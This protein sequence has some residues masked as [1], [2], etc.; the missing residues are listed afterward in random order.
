M[1]KD[2]E[3]QFRG[4]LGSLRCDGLSAGKRDE[5]LGRI[6]RAVTEAGRE[7]LSGEAPPGAKSEAAAAGQDVGHRSAA[8]RWLVPSLAAAAAIIV[9]VVGAMWLVCNGPAGP[10]GFAAVTLPFPELLA[11]SMRKLDDIETVAVT[12]RTTRA[13]EEEVTHAYYKRPNCWYEELSKDRILLDDGT[14]SLSLDLRQKKVLEVGPSTVAG[15]SI[16][17]LVRL[18][19]LKALWEQEERVELTGPFQDTINDIACQRYDFVDTM[20]ARP[21]IQAPER[22][23]TGSCWFSVESGLIQ[24]M[25]NRSDSFTG[26][27]E[28]RYNVPIDD[29]LF[30][31]PT[32]AEDVKLPRLKITAHDK[33]QQPVGQAKVYFGQLGRFRTFTTDERG[34]TVLSFDT[35]AY[36]HRES[37]LLTTGLWHDVVVES[38]DGAKAAVYTFA[39]LELVYGKGLKE[40]LYTR[41]EKELTRVG[42]REL[43]E[44]RSDIDLTYD[45]EENLVSLTLTLAP[46]ATVTGRVVGPDGDLITGTPVT[47]RAS[48]HVRGKRATVAYGQLDAQ[49]PAGGSLS[50]QKL[51][52]NVEDGG[53]FELVLPTNFPLRLGFQPLGPGF[54]PTSKETTLEAGAT[55]S[56]GDIVL[57]YAPQEGLQQQSSKP[58]GEGP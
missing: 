1:S 39:N 44:E 3:V 38:A 31:I 45:P 13:G 25:E 34:E 57:P 23:I 40:I 48:Y 5:L 51:Y 35:P 53:T 8:A 55:V 16:S 42:E 24:R 58:G 47:V 14:R 15:R 29:S 49:I 6:E 46:K 12:I 50:A 10:G 30:V 32:W 28:F 20:P 7:Q 19:Q 37:D 22:K 26:C 2:E 18:D 21:Q 27:A 4:L 56:L 11:E 33:Q 43:S 36:R 17:A 52:F 9:A 54:R 41:E